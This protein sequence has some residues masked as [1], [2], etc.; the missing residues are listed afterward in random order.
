MSIT[1]K[2]LH[3]VDSFSDTAIRIR[4]ELHM[5]PELSF[6]EFET[7]KKISE[8]ISKIGLT[9]IPFEKTTGL[10]T[11]IKSNRPNAKTL[12]I[13]AD[14]DALP[15][16]DEKNATYRSRNKGIMHAC[17]HDAHSSTL[18]SVLKVLSELKDELP[19]SIKGVFQP[20]EELGKGALALIDEGVLDG[21][22]YT[23]SLHVE[24]Y[25][26]LGS[27][28][29]RSGSTD[30]GIT[31]FTMKFSGIAA[32]G[33][34]PFLGAD[35]V[36]MA[37]QFITT[38][39][40]KVP[41]SVDNRDPMVLH[42]GTVTGGRAMNFVADS[43]VVTGSVRT[44][45]NETMKDAVDELRRVAEATV[46]MF[47]GSMDFQIDVQM[48]PVIND[49]FVSDA[50]FRASCDA[51]GKNNVVTDFP[52]SMG[53]EDFGAFLLQVPGAMVRVGV[54]NIKQQ[55]QALHTPLF[56][57]EEGAI[58]IGAKVLAL[59]VFELDKELINC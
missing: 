57:I 53:G 20:G 44:L 28:A 59:T 42:F 14:I 45:K 29:I 58:A 13:R 43:C 32:H 6:Q 48:A 4:R 54:G 1:S 51:I 47:G 30:A 9:P 26:P 34:R 40:A 17:G 49:A 15:I 39:Y 3:A 24:P 46:M 7:T 55:T 41:R 8:E 18:I 36:Q 33:A 35:A 10:Y 19:F 31:A 21:V 5:H 38:A 37:A 23:I 2:I 27:V 25:I 50:M 22:D 56:D 12:L 16:Q 52:A 11:E